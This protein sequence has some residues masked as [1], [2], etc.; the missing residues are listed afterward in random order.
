MYNDGTMSAVETLLTGAVRLNR[1]LGYERLKSVRDIALHVDAVAHLPLSRK[2]RLMTEGLRKLA[3]RLAR[4][5]KLADI[6]KVVAASWIV[7]KNPELMRLLG[8]TVTDEVTASSQEA[9]ND[10]AARRNRRGSKIPAEYRDLSPAYAYIT[11]ENFIAR[12][13]VT[14]KPAAGYPSRVVRA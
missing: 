13:G 8:F 3:Q 7:G 6:E 11:R 9:L 1:M 14:P 2:R 4:D 5:P 10:Y 12:Y